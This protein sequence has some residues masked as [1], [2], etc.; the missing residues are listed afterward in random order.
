MLRDP[1]SPYALDDVFYG[2]NESHLARF[3]RMMD[4]VSLADVNAAIGR[5]WQTANLRIAIVTKD[6]AGFAAALAADQPSPITYS[7]P[8]PDRVLEEDKAISAFPL[9]I[10]REAIRIVPVAELFAQ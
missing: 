7:S 4:E 2:L 6:A 3:R 8:K 9:K 1:G 10:K 5:Y